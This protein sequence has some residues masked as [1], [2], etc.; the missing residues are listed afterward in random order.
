MA[1]LDD[2]FQ[3]YAI[4]STLPFGSWIAD[5]SA[6]GA[7][8]VAGGSGI[9]GTDRHLSVNLSTVAYVHASYLSS[10]SQYVGLK[11][12]SALSFG[13]PSMTFANGPNGSGN[14]TTLLTLKVEADSTISAY[15]GSNALLKNSG[16]KWV[17]FNVWNFL[18][19]NVTLSDVAGQVH[20]LFELGLNGESAM[21]FDLDTSIAIANLTHATSEVNRFRLTGGRFAAYTLD[22]LSAI[23]AYPH[24]G[25]PNVIAYQAIAAVDTV[26]DD[27]AIEILQAV[28]EIDTLPNTAKLTVL[29]TIVELD[30][31]QLQGLRAEYIRRRHFPGD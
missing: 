18:Q 12:A 27:A 6:T 17:N 23:A 5:P 29:Q 13:Q 2:D 21:T 19:I 16:D 10:F 30:F 3:S 26:P 15:D 31:I 25:T 14:T 28:T 9:P 20:I 4:G 11:L 7:S 8:I 22:T 24:A 1:Y